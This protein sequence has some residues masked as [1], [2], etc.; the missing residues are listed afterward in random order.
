MFKRESILRGINGNVSF[1]CNDFFFQFKCSPSI[2][3]TLQEKKERKRRE[4][5]GEERRKGARRGERRG[6]ERQ[7]NHFMGQ[8][9]SVV[10]DT[11][12]SSKI[13]THIIVL[14]ALGP[15]MSS[16]QC[17]ST[18]LLPQDRAPAVGQKDN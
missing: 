15:M 7:N 13:N 9:Y 1:Y 11:E 14:E 10:H 17:V 6:E 5:R 2:F 8:E 16:G 12:W 3:H 18:Q 4:G